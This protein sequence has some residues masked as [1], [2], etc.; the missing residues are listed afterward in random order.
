MIKTAWRSFLLKSGAIFF[1]FRNFLFPIFIII[2]LVFTRP[3]LFLG[4]KNIDSVIVVAGFLIA[5]A[6]ALF[7]L[8]VIGFAYIKRGGKEGRVYADNLVTE[9][10]YAHVRNP[11]YIGN[12]FIIVGISLIY[13]SPWVYIFVIPFFSYVYLSIVVAEE[14][15][16]LK[17]F[18]PSYEAYCKQVNRFIPNFSGLKDTLKQLSYDWMKALRK[19]Y[20]TFL[21]VL[22]GCHITW[23]IKMYYFYDFASNKYKIPFL[24]FPFVLIGACYWLVRRLKKSGKLHP[25]KT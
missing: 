13:G 15:Y 12:F 24:V 25:A 7:R 5:L 10:I 19:D 17:H 2:L 22:V 23:I 18:G 6:G 14:N 4:R 16:L 1:R 11:M 20:G 8:F 9:G 3:A 21:G